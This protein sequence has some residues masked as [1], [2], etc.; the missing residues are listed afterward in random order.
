MLFL[1]KNQALKN[2]IIYFFILGG[3]FRG[4]P[5]PTEIWARK[6]ES[7]KNRVGGL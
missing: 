5:P 1:F 3:F 7:L 2:K 4:L 6:V